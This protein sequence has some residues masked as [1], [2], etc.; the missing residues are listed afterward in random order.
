MY[1]LL[2][3]YVELNLCCTQKNLSTLAACIQDEKIRRDLESISPE[4]ISSK[5]ISVLDLLEKFPTCCLPFGDYLAMLSPLRVRQ[6]SI[7]SSPLT[8]PEICT[9]TYSILNQ[10]AKVGGRRFLGA[11]S[12]YLA[13]L[14]AGEKIQVAVRPSHQAF[15]PPTDAEHVPLIMICAGTG[16]APFR[17]FV[18]ERAKQ[19]EAG[20]SLAPALLFIGCREPEKDALYADEL[21]EW[22]RRGVVDVRYA[23]S[24]APEKS[25]GCKYV[26]DRLLKDGED[27][28]KLWQNGGRMFVCGSGA[29]GDAIKEVFIKATIKGREARGESIT[30]EEAEAFFNSIR[31]ERF[32]TDVFA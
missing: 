15:H 9:L 10:E 24:R 3:A 30:W 22:A 18:E 14:T 6:Y 27:A 25:E 5:C 21:A 26:Q 8:R 11:A 7:S 2:S 17:G 32:A 29:I 31:N 16:L 13:E 12:N 4:E 23:F 28:R 1:S 20:R 19:Q